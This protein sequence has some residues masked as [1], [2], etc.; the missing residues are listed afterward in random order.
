ME[1]N[2]QD[3]GVDCSQEGVIMRVDSLL[4]EFENAYLKAN[5]M[6]CTADC[7]CSGSMHS[8]FKS[9]YI[10]PLLFNITQENESYQYF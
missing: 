3:F 4:N 5:D 1:Q 6:L 10:D 7:P 9:I 8:I 2:Q